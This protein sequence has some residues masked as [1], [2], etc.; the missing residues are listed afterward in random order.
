MEPVKTV[1][2]DTFA[3]TNG[4]NSS[5]VVRRPRA[6]PERPL[7]RALWGAHR[8]LDVGQQASLSPGLRGRQQRELGQLRLQRGHFRL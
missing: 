7:H 1:K 3:L 4:Q 2:V 6:R 5:S 8:L